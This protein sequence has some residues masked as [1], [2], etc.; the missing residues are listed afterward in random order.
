M[1][2]RFLL[3]FVAVVMTLGGCETTGMQM[4]TASSVAGDG[5]ENENQVE[6]TK[7]PRPIGV[8]ALAEDNY[9]NLYNFGLESP[10]PIVRVLMQKSGCFQVVDRGAASQALERERGLA[11]SGELQAGSNLGGG[12]MVAA[13]FIITPSVLVSDNDAGGS[14]LGGLIAGTMFGPTIGAIASGI[15]TEKRSANV[16]LYLTNVR[17]GIQEAAVEGS[18]TKNDI[19]F[20]VG[21]GA[22]YGGFAGAAG[23]AYQD[24]DLG[25]VIIAALVDAHNHLVAEMR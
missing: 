7:C 11:A 19:S 24:T 14:G 1:K 5:A 8:A 17:T 16:T 22:Y 4:G 9:Q 3:P 23:G 10:L 25:K 18:A 2:T 21:A 12:Q 20:G 6:L 13:D 15:S